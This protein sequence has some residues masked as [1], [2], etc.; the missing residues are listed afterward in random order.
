[1]IGL[2]IVCKAEEAV[3]LRHDMGIGLYGGYVGLYGMQQLLVHAGF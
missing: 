1:M 2:C 3:E